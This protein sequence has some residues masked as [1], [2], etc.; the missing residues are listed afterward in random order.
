MK[1]C[2]KVIA[3][4][5]FSLIVVGCNNGEEAGEIQEPDRGNDEEEVAEIQ[6]PDRGNDD[7]EAEEVDEVVNEDAEEVDDKAD[8]DEGETETE[9]EESVD[10]EESTEESGNT[11]E[12]VE[13]ARNE[14]NNEETN[15][16]DELTGEEILEAAIAAEKE[17]DALYVES[18]IEVDDGENVIEDHIKEWTFFH[19]DGSVE[20]RQELDGVDQ[21]T[22]FTASDGEYTIMYTEG[23][24]S[25]IRIDETGIDQDPEELVTQRTQL[26]SLVGKEAAYNGEDTVN[27]YDTYHVTF[28]NT[29]YWLEQESYVVI[30]QDLEYIPAVLEFEVDP[31]YSEELVSLEDVLPDD[32]EIIEQDASEM[33]G[34]DHG[35]EELDD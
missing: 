28:E 31:E 32:V 23:E 12:E 4:P 1:T 2:N 25:A 8:A 24:D 26:E 19:D 27:G 9:V 33:Y 14:D 18:V 5:L 15:E 34:E 6:E 7:E 21:P 17:R 11:D 10:V 20:V 29:D 22:Y 3:I 35:E 30:N 13:K 16:N